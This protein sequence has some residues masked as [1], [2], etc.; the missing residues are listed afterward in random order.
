MTGTSLPVASPAIPVPSSENKEVVAHSIIDSSR[1]YYTV[2][3]TLKVGAASST[4]SAATSSS[5]L[6]SSV[7][8]GDSDA[9]EVLDKDGK[10]KKNRC[11]T[12]RK[13]VGLTGM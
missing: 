10:K 4:L 7:A 11:A 9:A 6:S 8:E 5:S 2:F 1:S 3:E 12:C 13:K